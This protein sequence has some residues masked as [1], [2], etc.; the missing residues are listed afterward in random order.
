MKRILATVQSLEL[1]LE[2]ELHG[3]N[4]YERLSASTFELVLVAVA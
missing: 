3:K 2:L 1:E 4:N